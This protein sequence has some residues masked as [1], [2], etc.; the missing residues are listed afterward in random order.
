MLVHFIQHELF[1][2]PGA[3]LTWAEE[4][5][6]TIT[7]SKVYEY[8]PLPETAEHIDLLIVM[9]GPQSP[10]TPR[11]VCPHFDA[12]SEI[13]LIR[14]CVEADKIVFGVCLGAQLIGDALGGHFEHSPEKEI[15][16]YPIRLTEEGMQD[17]NIQH[18]GPELQVGH[19][20]GDMPGLTPTSKVLATS[21]GCPRQIVAYSDR[22]YGFQCH[23]EFT[24]EVVDLLIASDETDLKN[25][26][27]HRYIQ[28]PEEIRQVNYE[29]MNR[30]LF[31]FLDLLVENNPT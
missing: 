20:H 18:F 12:Q 6:Y 24:P 11:D 4:R 19:W 10:S 25:Q 2:S 7:F 30:K 1:E 26:T 5:G 28:T 27:N 3:I 14:K 21:E 29:E 13:A 23:L 15:G 9:G 31:Q 22:I 16:V 17:K 8:Q